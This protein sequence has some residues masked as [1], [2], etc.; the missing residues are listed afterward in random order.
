M[1]HF[2]T[3][4]NFEERCRARDAGMVCVGEFKLD[5]SPSESAMASRVEAM[6]EAMRKNGMTEMNYSEVL[7][8]I[9]T[10]NIDQYVVGLIEKNVDDAQ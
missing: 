10:N 9:R 5:T 6:R 8:A 4:K 1:D 3:S 2:C 7:R